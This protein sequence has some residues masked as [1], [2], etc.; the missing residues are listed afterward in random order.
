M[1][2]RSRWESHPAAADSMREDTTMS[3]PEKGE[4]TAEISQGEI[5]QRAWEIAK[6]AGRD[7]L[8]DGDLTTAREEVLGPSSPSI[9]HPP[10][11]H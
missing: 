2:F 7:T 6:A 5:E 9:A 1:K 8:D 4:G 11:G 10:T 3:E